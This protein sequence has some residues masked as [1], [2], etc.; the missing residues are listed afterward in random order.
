MA[1]AGARKPLD[2]VEEEARQII[3]VNL[4]VSVVQHDDNSRSSMP[5]LRIAY[6]DRPHGVVEVV[7]DIMEKRAKQRGALERKGDELTVPGLTWSWGVQLTPSASVRA[8]RQAL[9]ELLH[10]AETGG[11]STVEALPWSELDPLAFKLFELKVRMLHRLSLSESGSVMLMAPNSFSWNG[12]SEIIVGWCEALLLQEDDVP[13]KLAA[14]GFAERHAYLVPTME[15]D[16]A[17]YRA[18]FTAPPGGDGPPVMPTRI[19][20]L[21]DGVDQVWVRGLDRA[22]RWSEATGWVQVAKI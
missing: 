7:R 6:P 13:A 11:R 14:S 4:A 21:P 19:P 16:L 12:D 5:D 10:E 3:E 8:V 20:V 9:P 2:A 15:G 1:K 22:I 17:I 18:M